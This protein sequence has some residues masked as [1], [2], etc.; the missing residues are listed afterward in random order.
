MTAESTTSRRAGRNAAGREAE[1]AE[2]ARQVRD[3]IAQRRRA[4]A[5]RGVPN[6]S[7]SGMQVTW[8]RPGALVSIAAGHL[9]G[10]SVELHAG[11]V[12]RAREASASAAQRGA[13]AAGRLK[14][15]SRTRSNARPHGPELG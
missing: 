4:G 6:G 13:R 10:R 15:R 1:R 5:L 2:R 8:V 11:L 7:A 14:T 9:A 12:R 3:R